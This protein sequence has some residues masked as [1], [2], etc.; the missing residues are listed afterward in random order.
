[1][2][3]LFTRHTAFPAVIALTMLCALLALSFSAGDFLFHR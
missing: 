2:H 1:M 3:P